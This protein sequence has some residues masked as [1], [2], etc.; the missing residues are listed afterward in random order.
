MTGQSPPVELGPLL[1][2][3]QVARLLGVHPATI[4]RW[5]RTGKLPCVRTPGRHRRYRVADVELLYGA[6]LPEGQPP[7]LNPACREREAT[8]RALRVQVRQQNAALELLEAVTLD[9][10]RNEGALR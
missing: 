10:M 6:T 3:A 5:S 2:P 7:C 1:T 9:D 8:I 4:K